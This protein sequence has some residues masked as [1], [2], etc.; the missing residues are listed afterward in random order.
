MHSRPKRPRFL[1]TTIMIAIQVSLF[2]LLG[3]GD[4]LA[5]AQT[6]W[7]VLGVGEWWLLFSA[8]WVHIDPLHLLANVAAIAAFG[9]FLENQVKWGYYLLV[10]FGSGLVGNLG[11]LWFGDYFAISLGSSGVAIGLLAASIGAKAR[12]DWGEIVTGALFI[13]V[14]FAVAAQISVWVHVYGAAAGLGA[15]FLF[16][17][18]HTSSKN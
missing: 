2:F 9:L 4:R 5:L 3:S 8:S 11:H 12:I 10:Y 1:L 15:G 16:S 18:K 13:G 7:R 6:N 14:T 17:L